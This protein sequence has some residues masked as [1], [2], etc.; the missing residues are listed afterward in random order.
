MHG[1]GDSCLVPSGVLSG[2]RSLLFGW[3]HSSCMPHKESAEAGQCMLAGRHTG[4]FSFKDDAVHGL[5]SSHQF[6]P[7]ANFS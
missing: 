2:C 4:F 6:G 1:N 3:S 7:G 5:Q